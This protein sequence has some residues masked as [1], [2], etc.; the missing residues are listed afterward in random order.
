[1][2]CPARLVGTTLHD[3]TSPVGKPNTDNLG[4]I[5]RDEQHLFGPHSQKRSTPGVD[6]G[7]RGTHHHSPHGV[8]GSI[9]AVVLA[10]YQWLRS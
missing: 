3:H 5:G 6:P 7:G 1:L 9:A 8:G 10:W 2:P 4:H